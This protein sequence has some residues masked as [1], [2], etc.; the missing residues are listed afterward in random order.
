M[1]KSPL[2]IVGAK[3]SGTTAMLRACKT[4]LGYS[5]SVEGHVWQSLSV[6]KTHFRDLIR[7]FGGEDV[8]GIQGFSVITMRHDD[9][10][11]T[12]AAL[13]WER[14]VAMYGDGPLVDKTPDP[15]MIRACPVIKH[16]IP[17]ARFIFMK[18]R[19]IENVLSRGRRFP[20]QP[21]EAACKA[22]AQ[23]MEAW[24]YVRERLGGD[25]L[26]IDRRDLLVDPLRTAAAIAKFLDAGPTDKLAQFFT[27]TFAEATTPAQS[28][29]YIALDK[30]D[31][32]DEQKNIFAE[33][34]GAA[35]RCFGYEM[36]G[37]EGPGVLRALVHL[38]AGKGEAA[39]A[40]AH[41]NKWTAIK[42]LGIILHPNAIGT[43]PVEITFPSLLMPGRYTFECQIKIGSA[44]CQPQ[45]LKLEIDG[46]MPEQVWT[47]PIKGGKEE[48]VRWFIPRVDVKTTSS[49][50]I[51]DE[52][53]AGAKSATHSRLLLSEPHFKLVGNC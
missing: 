11:G 32:T 2:F 48:T 35:M 37:S 7:D 19:G 12:Y 5:G 45:R 28:T 52:L 25:Y 16:H 27:Q 43:K 21:F 14:H 4:V 41:G 15:A 30:A 24:L 9:L 17:D 46:A 18:R 53:G 10:I 29:D 50:K 38:T 23:S 8:K 20:E 33:T 39:A 47:K 13:L 49:V 1:P 6:L 26:E 40:I 42:R 22:W 3:R 34:C 51:V 36:E 31:W 44:R